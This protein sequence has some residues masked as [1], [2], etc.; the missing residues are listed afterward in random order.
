M[1]CFPRKTKNFG[2]V[3]YKM[4]A[5]IDTFKSN[6]TIPIKQLNKLKLLSYNN[7]YRVQRNKVVKFLL[8]SGYSEISEDHHL[9]KNQ[10]LKALIFDPIILLLKILKERP[11]NLL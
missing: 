11:N 2:G 10:F 9:P 1:L 3:L 6:V 7:K 8:V 5:Y 4:E